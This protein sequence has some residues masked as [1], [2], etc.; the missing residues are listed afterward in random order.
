MTTTSSVTTKWDLEEEKIKG[1]PLRRYI[2]RKKKKERQVE[3][4]GD[5]SVSNNSQRKDTN[6]I[7]DELI[8]TRYIR[9]STTMKTAIER[10]RQDIHSE[11]FC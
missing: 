3:K 8:K 5:A 6:Q 9:K 11:A 4:K 10:T 2:K 1:S 7:E